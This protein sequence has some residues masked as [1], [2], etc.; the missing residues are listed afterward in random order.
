MNSESIVAQAMGVLVHSQTRKRRPFGRRPFS[1]LVREGLAAV[2]SCGALSGTVT[3]VTFRVLSAGGLIFCD[4]LPLHEGDV[5]SHIVKD[6][7]N[8]LP[9]GE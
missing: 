2:A 1:M 3:A 7:L 6:G 9:D 4:W 5:V 8:A